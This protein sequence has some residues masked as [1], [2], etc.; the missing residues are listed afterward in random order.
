MKLMPIHIT[1]GK[2]QQHNQI[3]LLVKQELESDILD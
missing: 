2:Q 3:V 1:K